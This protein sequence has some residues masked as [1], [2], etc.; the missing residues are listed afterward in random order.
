M[1][2]AR[3]NFCKAFGR[4]LRRIR[5]EKGFGMREFALN[6]DIEYSQLSKI[7]RGVTNPTIGTVHLLAT[8]LGVSH[9]DLFDFPFE[10]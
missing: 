6:A 1:D 9:R 2:S 7:E 8:A 4:N 3:I 5:T 10:Y